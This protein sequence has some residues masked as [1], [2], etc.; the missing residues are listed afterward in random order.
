MSGVSPMTDDQLLEY[1]IEKVQEIGVDCKRIF[2]QKLSK[3]ED[4]L[5]REMLKY[6][7]RTA[8]KDAD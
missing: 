7:I 4:P 8:K 3:T 1:W 2:L 6:V 5:L